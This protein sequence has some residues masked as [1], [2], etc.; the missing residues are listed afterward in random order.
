LRRL[1]PAL[2]AEGL[3]AA[4]LARLAARMRRADEAIEAAVD[5]LASDPGVCRSEAD[6]TVMLDAARWAAAP[7]ELRLRLLGRH[8]EAIGHEGPVE[9]AKLEAC[10]AELAARVQCDGATARFR[11]TLAGAVMTLARGLLVI[12]PAPLRRTPR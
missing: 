6:G 11:R 2:A 3:D 12:A 10:A 9:L 1:L 5:A 4:A 7:A 8:V